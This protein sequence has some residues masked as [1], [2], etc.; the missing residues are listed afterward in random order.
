MISTLQKRLF[1]TRSDLEHNQLPRQQQTQLDSTL[2]ILK[3]LRCLRRERFAT[4]E[5]RAYAAFQHPAR[6]FDAWFEPMQTMRYLK[7]LEHEI[8]Y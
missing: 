4:T 7:I 6:R 8:D 5:N 1:Q 3:H 2:P